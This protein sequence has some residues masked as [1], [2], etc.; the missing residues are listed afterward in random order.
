MW[1]RIVRSFDHQ[2]LGILE[3][4]VRPRRDTAHKLLQKRP[5]ARAYHTKSEMG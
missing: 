5:S 3:I 4:G 1:C 2:N